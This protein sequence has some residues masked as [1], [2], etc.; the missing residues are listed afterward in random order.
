MAPRRMSPRRGKIR[1][2]PYAQ[3]TGVQQRADRLA[4]HAA[5]QRAKKAR[6]TRS[7]YIEDAR[8][9]RSGAS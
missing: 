3:I 9:R 2:T 8:Q 6:E 4:L 7:A 1:K 5:R